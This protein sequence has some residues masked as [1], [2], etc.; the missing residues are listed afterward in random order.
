MPGAQKYLQPT[1][2][3]SK[4]PGD[5]S[6]DWWARGRERLGGI[7]WPRERAGLVRGKFRPQLFA[8]V[9]RT[10]VLAI[11]VFVRSDRTWHS[12]GGSC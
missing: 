4:K 7:P 5:S 3:P 1:R 9:D 2:F 11:L 8:T 12:R 10:A 6:A